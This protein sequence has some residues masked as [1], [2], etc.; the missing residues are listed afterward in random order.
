MKTGYVY[1]KANK[2]NPSVP[3]ILKK[4]VLQIALMILLTTQIVQPFFV[5]YA[6]VNRNGLINN[7]NGP[8]KAQ[9]TG[10]E[11]IVKTWSDL[12]KLDINHGDGDA[13]VIE[14]NYTIKLKQDVVAASPIIIK[15]NVHI[16]SNDNDNKTIYREE[17]NTNFTVFTVDGGGTLTLG[18]KVVMSGQVAKNVYILTVT[19]GVGNALYKKRIYSNDVNKKLS[20]IMNESY[21]YFSKSDYT[22]IFEEDVEGTFH[23]D[24]DRAEWSISENSPTLNNIFN[25]LLGNKKNS[26]RNLGYEFGGWD[27]GDVDPDKTIAQIDGNITVV[28]KWNGHYNFKVTDGCRNTIYE[29]VIKENDTK[30]PNDIMTKQELIDL[31]PR[32]PKLQNILEEVDGPYKDGYIF[33]EWNYGGTENTEFN[34]ISSSVFVIAEWEEPERDYGFRVTDANGNVIYNDPTADKTKKINELMQDAGDYDLTTKTGRTA[35]FDAKLAEP[36]G[37]YKHE[38]SFDEWNYGKNKTG[39]DITPSDTL[40][41]VGGNLT[42]VA[43]W[44]PPNGLNYTWSLPNPLDEGTIIEMGINGKFVAL[45]YQETNT[46]WSN[47]YNEKRS[48]WVVTNLQDDGTFELVNNADTEPKKK[49]FVNNSAPDRGTLGWSYPTQIFATT[50]APN[51][52][53][54]RFQFKTSGDDVY[55]ICK[56]M[57]N[58]Y[59][60]NI[61]KEVYLIQPKNDEQAVFFCEDPQLGGTQIHAGIPATPF[62]N[63]DVPGY[64]EPSSNINPTSGCDIDNHVAGAQQPSGVIEQ[65]YTK[66]DNAGKTGVSTPNSEKRIDLSTRKDARYTRDGANNTEIFVQDRQGFFVQVNDRGTLDIEGATFKEFYAGN[67]VEN[68]GVNRPNTTVT[69]SAPIVVN[70]GT[71]HFTSGSIEN[72]EVGYSADESKSGLPVNSNNNNNTWRYVGAELGSGTPNDIPKPTKTAG[73]IIFKNNAVA[74]ITGDASIHNNKGDVGGI[75][76][77]GDSIVV[78]GGE[79]SDDT[80]SKS[81]GGHIDRNIG[82]HYSGAALVEGG[83]TLVMAGQNSTMNYNVSWN[84]GGAVWVTEYGTS[85]DGFGVRKGYQKPLNLDKRWTDSNGNVKPGKFLMLDGK[86]QYNTAFHRGGAINVESDYVIL[87]KGEIS[88]NNCRALGGGIY[89]EGDYADYNYTLQIDDG[90]IGHNYAVTSDPSLQNNRIDYHSENDQLIGHGYL[91]EEYLSQANDILDR[92]IRT[93]N[94]TSTTGTLISTKVNETGFEP[95]V[96]NPLSETD[97]SDD[98]SDQKVWQG[99]RRNTGWEGNGGGIWL[100]P[101]GSTGVFNLNDDHEVYID[102]NYASGATPT[103]PRDGTDIYLWPGTGHIIAKEMNGEVWENEDTHARVPNLDGTD[104]NS[105]IYTGPLPLINI[106]TAENNQTHSNY[107]QKKVQSKLKI[108]DNLSRNGGGI[109][110]NGTVLFGE[111]T[112]VDRHEAELTLTKRWSENILPE[113]LYFKMFYVDGST[114]IEMVGYDFELRGTSSD[115]SA[116]SIVQEYNSTTDPVT[117]EEL[118]KARFSTPVTATLTD[119]TV[120]PVY[121]FID[122][123]YPN[124]RNKDIDPSSAAGSA[125]IR[126][127]LQGGRT[128]LEVAPGSWKLEIR[129]YDSEGKQLPSA[130]FKDIQSLTFSSK[131]SPI[132]VFGGQGQELT[133]KHGYDIQFSVAQFAQEVVNENPTVEKYINNI[134]HEDF[135]SFDETF[136]YE[137]MAY[138]PA[139]ATEAII[140]DTLQTP[141]MFVDNNG[142]AQYTLNND[143]QVSNT[144]FINGNTAKLLISTVTYTPEWVN[145]FTAEPMNQIEGLAEGQNYFIKTK[146]G[147]Y[148]YKG[149]SGNNWVKSSETWVVNGYNN[150]TKHTLTS[151][152]VLY[153]YDS[154]NHKGD[155]TGTVST[156]GTVFSTSV[157]TNNYVMIGDAPG[158]GDVT[159]PATNNVEGNTLYVKIDES[160]GINNVRGKWVKVAFNAAIKPNYK[161]LSSLKTEGWVNNNYNKKGSPLPESKKSELATLTS[162]LETFVNTHNLSIAKVVRVGNRLYAKTTSTVINSPSTDAYNYYQL[163]LDGDKKWYRTFYTYGVGTSRVRI[164]D[165]INAS[166]GQTNAGKDSNNVA[167]DGIY[168][169]QGIFNA[170]DSNGG[171]RP[172]ALVRTELNEGV[173]VSLETYL[174]T[175]DSIKSLKSYDRGNIK[176][177][178]AETE[179]GD[180]YQRVREVGN[181]TVTDGV[182]Y[183]TEV[184]GSNTKLTP[185]NGSPKPLGGQYEIDSNKNALEGYNAVKNPKTYSSATCSD[186]D[187]AEFTGVTKVDAGYNWPVKRATEP[188][189]GEMNEAKFAVIRNNSQSIYK[190]NVVTFDV[191]QPEKY[192]NNRIHEILR[193]DQTAEGAFDQVFEYEIM[194]YVPNNADEIIIWD[195]LRDDLMFVDRHGKTQYKT[196]TIGTNENNNFNELKDISNS[197]F[198]NRTEDDNLVDS[199][200]THLGVT[201][202]ANDGKS[203]DPEEDTNNH[204]L[205][206]YENNN[207]KGDGTGTVATSGTDLNGPITNN[208]IVISTAPS[209]EV[210]TLPEPSLDTYG[211]N[212]G[213]TIYIKI[214]ENSGIKTVKGKWVKVTFFAQIK[215]SRYKDIVNKLQKSTRHTNNKLEAVDYSD[216][217]KNPTPVGYNYRT[218]D[219]TSLKLN[220]KGYNP[221]NDTVPESSIVGYYAKDADTGYFINYVDTKPSTGT[222]GVDY[223]PAYESAFVYH[224]SSLEEIP[225]EVRSNASEYEAVYLKKGWNDTDDSI[226]WEKV[227]NDGSVVDGI[228][229]YRDDNSKESYLDVQADGSHAGLANKANYS[230]R[231]DNEWKTTTT[232]TV[233]VVPL[234][235]TITVKKMWIMSNEDKIP[236]ANELLEHLH[237]YWERISNLENTSSDDHGKTVGEITQLYK[238]NIS[239]VQEKVENVTDK[240]RYTWRIEIKDLPQFR[241]SMKYFISED[242]FD[243]FNLPRYQN[244]SDPEATEHAHDTGSIINSKE[245]EVELLVTKKWDGTVLEEHKN[246]KIRVQLLENGHPVWK[247]DSQYRVLDKDGNLA[248]SEADAA[249]DPD[250]EKEINVEEDWFILFSPLMKYQRDLNGQIITELA[251]DKYGE[252]IVISNRGGNDEYLYREKLNEYS[253]KVLSDPN[254]YILSIVNKDELQYKETT[255]TYIQEASDYVNNNGEKTATV[256]GYYLYDVNRVN[257]E[258]VIDTSSERFLTEEPQTAACTI[259]QGLPS[260]PVITSCYREVYKKIETY[261]HFEVDLVNTKPR[262]EKYINKDVHLDTYFINDFTYDI[263]VYVPEEAKEIEITDELLPTLI[264]KSIDEPEISGNETKEIVGYNHIFASSIPAP[265]GME[266]NLAVHDGNNHKIYGTVNTNSVFGNAKG[267]I[268]KQGNGF[269]IL[270]DNIVPYTSDYI[271]DSDGEYIYVKDD[272]GNKVYKKASDELVYYKEV[273]GVDASDPNSYTG[274]YIRYHNINTPDEY[275]YMLYSEYLTNYS[276]DTDY[277]IDPANKFYEKKDYL[278]VDNYNYRK[279]NEK[280]YVKDLYGQFIKVINTN[281]SNIIK[282]LDRTSNTPTGYILDSELYSY[283]DSHDQRIGGKYVHVTF[284]SRI[285]IDGYVEDSNGKYWLGSDDNYYLANSLPSGVT[286]KGDKKYSTREEALKSWVENPFSSS[287]EKDTLDWDVITDYNPG[288]DGNNKGWDKYVNKSL[289]SNN[290]PENEEYIKKSIFDDLVEY[291][292]NNNDSVDVIINDFNIHD[293]ASYFVRTTSG[294]YYQ[295][296]NVET[297]SIPDKGYREL[298]KKWY[299]VEAN[300]NSSD[301][302]SDNNAKVKD[303][304]GNY[305]LNISGNLAWLGIGYGRVVEKFN[306]LDTNPSSFN[307]IDLIPV[308]PDEYVMIENKYYLKEVADVY[309]PDYTDKTIYKKV[310]WG[311]GDGDVIREYPNNFQGNQYKG[312]HA[313]IVNT[314]SYEVTYGNGYKSNHKSNTVTVVPNVYELPSS[315]GI[316]TFLFN[317]LGAMFIS[318][319]L[320]EFTS[321]RRKR[322]KSI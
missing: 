312:D 209:G 262:I 251:K 18:D 300:P 228:K 40:G 299:E 298:V 186:L 42:V 292:S 221:A 213:N 55:L 276:S 52:W 10:E 153:T 57:F 248:T 321:S 97:I 129:E 58:H 24:W 217:N 165:A 32:D 318:L 23:D 117:G 250:Y 62:S 36:E 37:P 139:D 119:G 136:E 103:D 187:I 96:L 137:I 157:N 68:N 246:E 160:T 275:S 113:D 94:D 67:N 15:G 252:N 208:N 189:S 13:Y 3:S 199:V 164:D 43:K 2:A 171:N 243:G 236:S 193:H 54:S 313:G 249:I 269:K 142:N 222:V 140:Y 264:F 19:D 108:V 231:F 215:P 185:L 30:T 6:D 69:D 21:I 267:T 149:K 83:G 147:N 130:F 256:I 151:N 95:N 64:S 196:Y 48:Q 245:S 234:L 230:I 279:K 172:N 53:Y 201:L 173:L 87:R 121:K 92:K 82:F 166:D 38:Y 307:T 319:A 288:V 207:H 294:K 277:E 27:Y 29:T 155:G 156:K 254:D 220:A 301:S 133:E 198:M 152:P 22:A 98:T 183:K 219:K 253:I 216:S 88:Y 101:I 278:K 159:M 227:T 20:E 255:T 12:E 224:A 289:K 273:S 238:N 126:E 268:T 72:N 70:K 239:I 304:D 282:Y 237:L 167:L 86:I 272:V 162:T 302:T 31:S 91:D 51:N 9:A 175:N 303:F 188:H 116:Y 247:R 265:E 138:I 93:G 26:P 258:Y 174:G 141:L 320:I 80:V 240:T 56:N 71:L 41:S 100:C 194:T 232:N 50:E 308:E 118:W 179:K 295:Y 291:L 235:R 317:I 261:K 154:N 47:T 169:I 296:L 225:A 105:R 204:Q 34:Q 150:N 176:I 63:P 134:V 148:Y 131:V 190:S 45:N 211:N 197:E 182:W 112:D 168:N 60:G 89:V 143:T 281:D 90:Y 214:D 305:G 306:N 128:S 170:K 206:Y 223:I 81:D 200:E 16:S 309:N 191:V 14:G 315:G 99:Y 229:L 195:T 146:S 5:A 49:L 311:R 25:T 76:V 78:L 39:T 241:P 314:A 184:S 127:L 293:E 35:A 59:Y 266:V 85:D 111:A 205:Q 177:Y 163:N 132:K 11:V 161:N 74:S 125:R 310:D 322:K 270:I 109:A 290:Y 144:Q 106:T 212:I 271:V 110:A 28:A 79:K 66:T 102:D 203:I 73:G 178:I 284:T 287:N 65:A 8:A 7:N 115:A 285:N 181:V 257:E 263:M 104:A 122:P 1:K 158:T 61:E 242:M 46:D 123:N 75:L 233:T 226:S 202:V 259:T 210:T 77:Q 124:D 17:D 107:D 283:V 84:K 4:K 120:V 192:V 44:T 33:K 145:D 244:P 274:K 260:T 297:S 286:R 180:Y 114:E 135:Y 316:G 218:T 280:H